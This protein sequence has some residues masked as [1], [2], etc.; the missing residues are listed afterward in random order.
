M[1]SFKMWLEN[2]DQND[3]KELQAVW[4]DTF[5]ALGIDGLSDEDAAQHSLSKIIFNQRSSENNNEFRGKRAARK[6]LENG[7]IFEKLNKINNPE[8]KK[9]IEDVR[10]WL[11]TDDAKHAANA[12]TTVSTLLQKL[13]GQDNFSKLI[14]SNFPK[15]DSSKAE[16]PM[17]SPKKSLENQT[18]KPP[19]NNVNAPPMT[20]TMDQ[21]QV[22][23]SQQ[24]P[25]VQNPMPPKP[26]G[27]E[28]GLF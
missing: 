9:N 20:G 28:M 8:I 15:I 18:E 16:V 25:P 7:Q 3:F 5:K 11:D 13:F 17:M 21:P 27:A 1:T 4:E 10:K 24:M 12:S 14:D 22:N 19:L 6:R 26:A 2:T 23:P